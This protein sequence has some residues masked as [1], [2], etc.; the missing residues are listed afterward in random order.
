[1]ASTIPRTAI[2]TGAAQGIGRAIAIRLAEDGYNVAISDLASQAELLNGVAAEIK[3][4][5]R[6]TVIVI[7]DVSVEKDVENLV[8]KAVADLGSLEIV[9]VQTLFQLSS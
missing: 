8:Q 9:R 7:A 5:G 1:M 4:K 6:Q 3:Q 2:V